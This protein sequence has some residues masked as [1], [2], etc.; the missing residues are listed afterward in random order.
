MGDFDWEFLLA[1]GN[2]HTISSPKLIR[3][4]KKWNIIHRM[5]RSIQEMKTSF[6][7]TDALFLYHS[8]TLGGT[9]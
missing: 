2:M 4:F 8:I 3:E 9:V 5:K 1:I 7:G 6:S